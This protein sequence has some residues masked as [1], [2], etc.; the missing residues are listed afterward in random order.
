MGWMLTLWTLISVKSLY[1][2]LLFISNSQTYVLAHHSSW[3]PEC[4]QGG[5]TWHNFLVNHWQRSCY[6]LEDL[7]YIAFCTYKISTFKKK[8][9][10]LY[11]K[12]FCNLVKLSW[13]NVTKVRWCSLSPSL[14]NHS[15]YWPC[16]GFVLKFVTSGTILLKA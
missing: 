12:I 2:V 8:N 5:Q 4:M 16:L 14:W 13:I 11:T 7:S 15:L 3:R 10:K 1:L 9:S 6:C